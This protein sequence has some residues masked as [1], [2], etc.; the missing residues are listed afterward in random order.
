MDC[1]CEEE[2]LLSA[3]IKIVLLIKLTAI[4]GVK[5]NLIVYPI[6]FLNK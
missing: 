1:G 5:I 6:V 4:S 2:V 3:T